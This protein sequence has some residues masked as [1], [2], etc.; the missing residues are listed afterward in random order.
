M[1]NSVQKKKK[2]KNRKDILLRR[3]GGL[4][5]QHLSNL[6]AQMC[7]VRSGVET[8][9]KEPLPLNPEYVSLKKMTLCPDK[10]AGAETKKTRGM[11]GQRL[12]CIMNDREVLVS[13]LLIVTHTE[14][15]TSSDKVRLVM[16]KGRVNYL[17][18]RASSHQLSVKSCMEILMSS[19]YLRTGLKHQRTETSKNH[20]PN[21]SRHLVM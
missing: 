11:K 1:E 14:K 3:V 5:V 20:S 18:Q 4:C 16:D 13:D 21:S 19:H 8:H 2:K 6:P 17:V 12:L 15:R 10:R 7:S 9:D